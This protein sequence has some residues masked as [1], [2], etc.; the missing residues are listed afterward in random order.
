MQ[1]HLRSEGDRRRFGSRPFFRAPA[2]AAAAGR[3]TIGTSRVRVGDRSP[4][5]PQHSF[6]SPCHGVGATRS[7]AV[8]RPARLRCPRD[9]PAGHS[10]ARRGLQ[11]CD[12][13]FG[14]RAGP[15]IA[16]RGLN[17]RGTW[18]RPPAASTSG[19][20]WCGGER[21]LCLPSQ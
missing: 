4:E 14:P 20:K 19:E 12:F 13:D 21:R 18:H 15:Y 2:P 1:Q 5:L 11:R 6:S 7:G 8:H 10:S 16:T 17:G 3:W 9:I